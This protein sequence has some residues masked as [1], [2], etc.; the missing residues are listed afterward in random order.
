V[1]FLAFAFAVAGMR[2]RQTAESGESGMIRRILRL[3][4]K[5]EPI[6]LVPG[7]Y[8][9]LVPFGTRDGFFVGSDKVLGG[10]CL[11][12]VVPPGDLE[13]R[14]R[15]QHGCKRVVQ[16]TP[17][18]VPRMFD[19]GEAPDGSLFTV[20]EF[21]D[22]TTAFD[23]GTPL[24]ARRAFVLELA[25]GVLD[26][27]AKALV[28]RDIGVDTLAVTPDSRPLLY[29][30]FYAAELK[31]DRIVATIRRFRPPGADDPPEAAEPEYDGVR[32]DIFSVCAAARVLLDPTERPPVL[33]E[34]L[35]P[36]P[37][38]RPPSMDVLVDRLQREWGD[39]AT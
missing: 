39:A 9:G 6:D 8:E 34:G 33:D 35:D 23:A 17:T 15:L 3:F 13:A 5:R 14:A 25:R 31:P 1:F 27:H 10:R 38:N 28:H 18:H 22:G 30:V 21:P 19:L 20:S 16:R 29:T 7:R 37:S 2:Y 4:R 36:A 24:P 12:H 11:F 26:L 32:G